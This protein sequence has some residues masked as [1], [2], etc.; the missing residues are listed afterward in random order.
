LKYR[1]RTIDAIPEDPSPAAIRGTL[2]HRVLEQLFALDAP[3]RTIEQA[4]YLVEANYQHLEDTSES[5]ARLLNDAGLHRESSK[6][7]IKKYFELE[8]PRRIAVGHCELGIAAEID[9]DFIIRGFV[10]RV[11]IATNQQ[12][13]IVDYKT[14]RSPGPQ[15]E[16][17][18]MFQMRFYALTWWRS[19]GSIPSVLQLLYLASRDR[20]FYEPD[21]ADLLSTER[22]ILAIRQAIMNAAGKKD[23]Q[24]SPSRLCQWCSY[25]PL[26][27]AFDGSPP[28]LPDPQLWESGSIDEVTQSTMLKDPSA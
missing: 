28:P 19:T 2:I 12:V 11:D 13:R 23:F 20:L 27:P 10:D 24:P 8:D 7:L 3:D 15:H 17:N 25:K 14:G 1:L 6:V 16:H 18:A 26:C 4:D 21:E 9:S 5:S 22:K